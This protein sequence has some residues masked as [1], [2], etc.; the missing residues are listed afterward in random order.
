M[1]RIYAFCMLA[2]TLL[3][4]S[5]SAKVNAQCT[6]SWNEDCPGALELWQNLKESEYSHINAVTVDGNSISVPDDNYYVVAKE[7][8]M[9]S[10]IENDPFGYSRIETGQYY[11]DCEG[12]T[13]VQIR[14]GASEC[15]GKTYVLKVVN[16]N[17]VVSDKQFTINIENGGKFIE[18]IWLDPSGEDI[19]P[20]GNGVERIVTKF[21]SDAAKTLYIAPNHYYPI[22]SLTAFDGS[23]NQLDVTFNEI[24]G[25]YE[26]PLSDGLK[27]NI[28]VFEEGVP[29]IIKDKIKLEFANDLAKDALVMISS[30][31]TVG[32]GSIYSALNNEPIPTMFEVEDGALTTFAWNSADYNM[33]V[34]LDGATQTDG[35]FTTSLGDKETT[36]WSFDPEGNCTVTFS[37]TERTWGNVYFSFEAENTEG[38]VF[39]DGG[40]DGEII[41]ISKY[42]SG[43]GERKT[44]NVPVSLRHPKIFVFPAEG[45]YVLGS[46]YDPTEKESIPE[47]ADAMIYSTSGDNPG[48]LY[49][50]YYFKGHK[51]SKTS[52][53][54][55]YLDAPTSNMTLKDKHGVLTDAED[56]AYLNSSDSES[57]PMLVPGYNLIYVDPIYSQEI[58]VVPYNEAKF[59]VIYDNSQTISADPDSGIFTAPCDEDGVLHIASSNPITRTVSFDIPD[60]TT[61]VT[62]HLIKDHDTSA[63]KTTLSTLHNT[64]VTITPREGCNV[65]LDGEKLL[66][67]QSVQARSYQPSHSEHTYSFNVTAD[68]SVAVKYE[69]DANVATVVPASDSKVEEVKEFT[70]SFPNAQEVEK[71]ASSSIFDVELI[72]G[73]KSYV[74]ND[75]LTEEKVEGDVPT[76]KYVLATPLKDAGTYKFTMNGGYFNIDNDLQSQ[77][78]TATYTI[79]PKLVQIAGMVP[80]AGSTV[81]KLAGVK[82]IVPMMVDEQEISLDID[83]EVLAKTIVTLNGET[84]ATADLS[85]IEP[86]PDENGNL[87]IPVNFNAPIT[88]DGQN[89]TVVVPQGAFVEK[90]WDATKEEMVPVAGGYIT[91][92]FTATFNIDSSLKTPI[93]TY[94]LSPADGA[95]VE[96]ISEILI[97]FPQIE[98]SQMFSNYEFIPATFTQG[99]TTIEGL[100]SYDW[101][102]EEEYRVMKVTPMDNEES[103]SITTSGEWTLTIAAGT[104]EL[105][106]DSSPEITATY[107]VEAGVTEPSYVLT[108]AAGN[109]KSLT[110]ITVNF[111]DAES[112]EEVEGVNITLVGTEYN[113]NASEVAVA[114]STMTV[115][116]SFPAASVDGE[117]TLTIPAGAFKVN[118]EDSEEIVAIYNLKKGWVIVPSNGATVESFNEFIVS[119]PDATEVEYVGSTS[120]FML[121][122]LSESFGF[123]NFNCSKVEDAEV[124][125]YSITM[126]SSAQKPQNGNYQFYIDGGTFIVDGEESP[127]IFAEYTLEAEVP[128]EYLCDPF[129]GTIVK[130]E[131]GIGFTLIFDEAAVVTEPSASN[132]KITIDETVVPSSAY[133]C[134]AEGNM[135]MF[136]IWQEQY[137]LTGKLT[138]EIPAGAFKVGNNDS[139]AINEEWQV[140]EPKEFTIVLPF[141]SSTPIA[142]PNDLKEIIISIPEA[143]TATVKEDMPN[144]WI[145]SADYSFNETGKI[146]I[147]GTTTRAGG[148]DVKITFDNVPSENGEYKLVMREGKLLLDNAFASPAIEETFFV[149]KATGIYSIYGDENGNV[150]VITLDGKVVL[151]NVPAEQLRELERGIYI[152][153]GKKTIVK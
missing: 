121:R 120:S 87:L 131:Y 141:N 79:E 114:T 125:T 76:Y 144:P 135:L 31:S 43:T 37:A 82:L 27:V 122:G 34:K 91:D 140:V 138:L 49:T 150:T 78:I 66:P 104:F 30:R 58:N 80:E 143:T 103:T 93:E 132:V 75:G 86:E 13:Y 3:G 12:R 92:A 126:P 70:V 36:S 33:T 61:K 52:P 106:G 41:D 74:I 111:P 83:S 117:Y 118:G 137:Y 64:L 77:P 128:V 4:I 15:R 26:I 48:H 14:G 8:Y 102:S 46:Y 124:P 42:A 72:A 10:E 94:T 35:F 95:T 59:N 151:N 54:V 100:V 51:I 123:Q 5:F 152:I 16:L 113:A 63:A 105:D 85:D 127:E 96:E 62:Y 60:K 17:Q 130:G 115:N 25:I 133:A 47:A 69:G 55:I 40:A 11:H 142:N 39:R 108:P 2:L 22:Y 71:A 18:R 110:T 153:N 90:E 112:L 149:D 32:E 129:T 98:A 145:V 7:G 1:K 109:V 38:L 139:P 24:R 19:V 9:I 136:Q 107:T 28:K 50:D 116:L 53:Y 56:K 6:V 88:T 134:F 84:V 101:G 89:Y 20:T 23:N 147:L 146:E 148:V 68:H 97:S 119:F 44:Y 29:E 45:W 73:D 21:S 65:Y 57:T 67:Q 81:K 99:E